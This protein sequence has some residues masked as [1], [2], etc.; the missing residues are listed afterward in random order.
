MEKLKEL[1]PESIPVYG[2]A[3]ACL[4]WFFDSAIN[5]FVFKTQRLYVENL[6]DPNAVELCARCQVITLLIAFSLVVMFMLRRQRRIK[7]QLNKYQHEFEHTVDERTND[8]SLINTMLKE[9]IMERQ[10][11]EKELVHLATIDP[12]TSIPNRRKFDDVLHYELNR[13]SRY[14]NKLSMIFCDLDYFKLINDK[15]GH[16]IGDDILKEFTRLVLRNI[17]RTD[18]FARWGGEEFV[19]LLPETNIATATHAAEKLRIETENHEFA[20]VGTM[21]ASFGVTQFSD[22]DNE[23]SFIN[24]ADDALYKSKEKGRNRVEV[25]QPSHTLLNMATTSNTIN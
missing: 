8:L 9:E 13:D 11:I 17:R 20:Y 5:T 21:T 19:L 12:L 4:F 22:G 6:L 2:S 14:H 3:L 16:K 1:R 25:F 24:R 23:T 10:K 18:V 15:Y 7:T